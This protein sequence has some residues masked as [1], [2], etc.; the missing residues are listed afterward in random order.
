M[1]HDFSQINRDLLATWFSSKT[2]PDEQLAKIIKERNSRLKYPS[3]EEI[4]LELCS[5]SSVYDNYV[6]PSNFTPLSG[7]K[8]PREDY[9]HVSHEDLSEIF[10]AR[11]GFETTKLL[12]EVGSFC[13]SSALLFSSKL[14]SSG[15]LMIC[16]DTWLGDINMRMSSN[17]QEF[18][19]LNNGDPVTYH[20]FMKSMIDAGNQKTVVPLRLPSIVA[21]R[22]L[23]VTN[24]NIDAVYLDSAHEAGETFLEAAMYYDLLQ[25]GGVIFGDDYHLFP[26]V[27]RDIDAFSKFVRSNLMFTSSGKVWFIYKPV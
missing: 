15:G 13:G 14:R 3:F 11:G 20:H 9:S 25:P 8:T 23:R 1:E 7:V 16:V 18:M 19:Q 5:C 4:N 24:Y 6:A 10:T 2:Q 12:V 17:F 22:T 21:A 26:A 27:K